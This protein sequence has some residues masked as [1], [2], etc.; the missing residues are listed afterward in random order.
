[1]KFSFSPSFIKTITNKIKEKKN[2]NKSQKHHNKF[3]SIRLILNNL[4]KSEA[5]LTQNHIPQKHEQKGGNKQK[6]LIEA[7]NSKIISSL[8][9][10]ETFECL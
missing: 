2:Q 9:K 4:K 6:Q 8:L 7:K 10:I 3:I 5:S 1:M